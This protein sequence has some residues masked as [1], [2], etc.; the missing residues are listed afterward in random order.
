MNLAGTIAIGT[1]LV[2]AVTMLIS[3]LQTYQ[4][5]AQTRLLTEATRATNKINT[6]SVALNI[7]ST[8]H[9]LGRLLIKHPEL[10][11]Y[12]YGGRPIPEAGPLRTR[13]LTTAEMF[14]D[15]IS[16][17]LDQ[18]PL[19]A[20]ETAEVWQHYFRDLVAGSCVLQQWWRENREWY[21]TPVRNL[22]DP[23]VFP[24]GLEPGKRAGEAGAG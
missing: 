24:N 12:I 10:Y 4:L 17:T 9:D 3:A 14:L 2:V 22:L 13:V 19:L 6:A 5:T 11:P 7:N 20:N 21:E 15:F 8:M 23:V 1:L 18:S 16:M